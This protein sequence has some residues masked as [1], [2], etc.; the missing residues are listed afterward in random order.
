MIPVPTTARRQGVQD[1]VRVGLF[2]ARSISNK[3]T[4][5]E[6]W[7]ADAKLNVAALVETWHDDA[8]SP[9]LIACAPLGFTFIEKARPR[10]DA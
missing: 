1:S 7:I 5:I 4:S 9:D 8:A 10:N 2:N 3:S 6:R